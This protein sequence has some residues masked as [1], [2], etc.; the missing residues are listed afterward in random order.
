MKL[1]VIFS[2]MCMFY[3]LKKLFLMVFVLFYKYLLSL[4]VGL[5]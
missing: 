1:E 4:E 2:G 5:G 3:F